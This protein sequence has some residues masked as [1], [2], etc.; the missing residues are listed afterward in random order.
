MYEPGSRETMFNELSH[1]RRS[2]HD[3]DLGLPPHV[4]QHALTDQWVHGLM[5]WPHCDVRVKQMKKKR[6]PNCRCG[7][8]YMSRC[9]EKKVIYFIICVF[10]A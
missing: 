2:H 5:Y 3:I 4:Q 10:F 6:Q 8:M 7:I 9:L 1:L